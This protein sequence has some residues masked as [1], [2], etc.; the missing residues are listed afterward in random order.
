MEHLPAPATAMAVIAEHLTPGG[1]YVAH[2]PTISSSLA[3]WFY[4]RSY[5]RDRTHVFR[6]SG[7]EFNALAVAAGMDVV[8]S[9]YSPFWPT[10]LWSR[11]RP[12]PSYLAVFRRR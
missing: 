2:L 8:Q 10:A 5:A 12:H 6:P 11:L 9:L 7:L 4:E 1:L 3:A